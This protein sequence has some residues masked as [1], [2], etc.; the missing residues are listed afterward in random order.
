MT[1]VKASEAFRTE[2][3]SAVEFHTDEEG[4]TT[5]SFS[6]QG[7]EGVFQFKVENLGKEN[8]R[9]LEDMEVEIE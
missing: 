3:L 5:I 4:I 1:K 2:R 7:V 8:E 9:I 6:V